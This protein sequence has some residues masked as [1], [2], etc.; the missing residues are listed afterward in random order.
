MSA[1]GGE[2]VAELYEQLAERRVKEAVVTLERSLR[3]PGRA[4]ALVG[5]MATLFEDAAAAIT[6]LTSQCIAL[7]HVRS[8]MDALADGLI[9]LA[10]RLELGADLGRT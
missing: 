2:T 1:A 9:S 3:D 7:G 5:D 10:G 4:A 6:V 8:E